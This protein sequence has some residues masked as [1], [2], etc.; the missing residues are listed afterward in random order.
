MIKISKKTIFILIIVALSLVLVT[1]SDLLTTFQGGHTIQFKTTPSNWSIDIARPYGSEE[2][3]NWITIR[4]VTT[5]ENGDGIAENIPDGVYRILIT[6]YGYYTQELRF[7]H[8]S[9]IFITF[10]LS[11]KDTGQ[12]LV[13]PEITPIYLPTDQEPDIPEEI[14]PDE[15]IEHIST[16]PESSTPPIDETPGFELLTFLFSITLVL[17]I[18]K[19]RKK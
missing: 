10:V 1:Q 16:T 3:P 11:E 8:S 13:E 9:D 14:V 17:I 18:L 2:T 7:T 6:K 5:D 19:R 4:Q 12:H 15:I